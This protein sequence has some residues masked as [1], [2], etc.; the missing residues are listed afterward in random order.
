MKERVKKLREL[1][2]NAVNRISAERGLL[3]TEYYK[4]DEAGK[5]SIPVQ[6][7]QALKYILENKFICINEMELI[8]GERG[9]APKA[10]PTY[11]EITLHSLEDLEILNS[12]KKVFFKVDEVLGDGIDAEVEEHVEGGF[13]AV[14]AGGVENAGFVSLGGGE[15]FDLWLGDEVG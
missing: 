1:S 8:V 4:S 9:P 5:V 6:R 11:P 7:A 10:T 13:H 2:L 14:D 12:R 3:V 15:E